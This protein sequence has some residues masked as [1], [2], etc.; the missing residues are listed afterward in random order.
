VRGKRARGV[1]KQRW[2]EWSVHRL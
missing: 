1:L 2:T